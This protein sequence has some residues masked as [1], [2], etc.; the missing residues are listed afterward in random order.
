MPQYPPVLSVLKGTRFA[1]PRRL[2]PPLPTDTY[3]N[4]VDYVEEATRDR[5]M[6]AGALGY[7]DLDFKCNKVGAPHP[8]P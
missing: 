4:S 3:F 6:P 2:T 7:K 8:E 5:V 1:S